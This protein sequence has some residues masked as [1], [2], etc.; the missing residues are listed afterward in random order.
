ME[1]IFAAAMRQPLQGIAAVS[2]AADSALATGSAKAFI[3]GASLVISS[4]YHGLVN[5]LSQC[6][7]AIGTSWSHKYPQLF[8]EYG[9]DDALWA[10]DDPESAAARLATWLDG[11]SI[12]RRRDALR[13]PAASLKDAARQ[14][15]SAVA[16]RLAPASDR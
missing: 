2:A 13:A 7:P 5:A 15:W 1:S 11:P 16:A 4:R 9:C 3:G 14:M 8:A 12:D 10:V 6:V